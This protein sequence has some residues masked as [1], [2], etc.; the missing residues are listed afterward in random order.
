MALCGCICF[1]FYG[2][3]WSYLRYLKIDFLSPLEKNEHCTR[4]GS[5]ANSLTAMT[6]MTGHQLKAVPQ[7]RFGYVTHCK[8]QNLTDYTLLEN[9][10]TL[11]VRPTQTFNESYFLFILFSQPHMTPRSS[12]NDWV[13]GR[14]RRKRFL[15]LPQSYTWCHRLQEKLLAKNLNQCR[16]FGNWLPL[17]RF[18]I[19]LSSPAKKKHNQRRCGE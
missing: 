16:K 19:V 10:E 7:C 13:K 17:T 18:V 15:S 1:S 9:F 6:L 8:A 11:A 5:E 12:M 4:P 3:V 14:T 2:T